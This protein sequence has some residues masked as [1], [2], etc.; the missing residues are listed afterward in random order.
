MQKLRDVEYEFTVIPV[1]KY[2]T[3]DEYITMIIKYATGLFAPAC[4]PTLEE[5]GIILENLMYQ[6]S[7][8]VKPEYIDS[9]VN[10]QRVRNEDS[11]KVLTE[12]VWKS[13]TTISLLH[14]YNWGNLSSEMINYAISGDSIVPLG[15][16]LSR[17]MSL[18]IE[19]SIGPKNA[20]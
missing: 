12:I 19:K 1:P 8:N 6:S 10:L 11:Y 5:T 7:R 3:T 20:G 2:K 14:I 16:S 18:L 4:T 15:Q 9:I 13:K 17:S